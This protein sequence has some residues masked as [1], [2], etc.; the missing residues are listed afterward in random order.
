MKNI[1]ERTKKAV[2]RALRDCEKTT[3]KVWRDVGFGIRQ[4]NEVTKYILPDGKI[5]SFTAICHDVEVWG[6]LHGLTLNY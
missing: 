4:A 1:D 3:T 2:S 6:N 5:L